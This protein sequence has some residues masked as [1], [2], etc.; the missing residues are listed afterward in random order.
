M[1]LS[2]DNEATVHVRDCFMIC[3]LNYKMIL[4]TI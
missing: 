4:F 3:I 1:N 2:S